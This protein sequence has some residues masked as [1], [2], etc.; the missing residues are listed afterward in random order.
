MAI[1]AVMF[2][3]DG[4]LADTLG[5][6]VASANHARG[7]VGLPPI[8]T[9]RYRRLAGQG[10]HRLFRDALPPEQHGLVGPLV[11]AFRDH[12][13]DHAFDTTGPYDGVPALLDALADAGRALAVWSNKPDAATRLVVD[14][15]FGRWP[16]AA[17]RGARDGTPI[18]PDPAGA[19]A[20]IEELAVPAAA[21][22]YVGDTDVDMWT[23]RAAGM[24]TVGVTWGFRDEDELRGAG[25]QAIIHRPTE[26]SPL[27]GPGPSAG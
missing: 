15:L 26:L 6:I 11:T 24:F 7:T 13:A 21:W 22:A 17:V 19:Q 16:W 5:D 1:Q 18:K 23:G 25:A 4:T 9:P 10:V 3:L 8:E 12:Y 14:R 20:V 27:L 2:D